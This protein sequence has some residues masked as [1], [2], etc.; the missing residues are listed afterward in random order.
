MI[1]NSKFSIQNSK[2]EMKPSLIGMTL[3][4]LEGVAKQGGMP[5][6]VAKQLADWLYAKRVVSFE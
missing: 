3:Q 1:L 6:F 5:R 2:L 4:D